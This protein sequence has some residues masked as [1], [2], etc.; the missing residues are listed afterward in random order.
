MLQCFQ[1]CDKVEKMFQKY[2]FIFLLA[3]VPMIELRGSIIFAHSALLTLPCQAK[4]FSAACKK[5]CF[6]APFRL[7]LK[8]GFDRMVR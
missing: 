2:L 1:L 8:G 6:G 3:M 5:C 7:T 4:S